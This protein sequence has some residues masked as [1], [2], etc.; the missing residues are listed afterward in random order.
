MNG[1]TRRAWRHAYD[2]SHVAKSTLQLFSCARP[3]LQHTWQR[4]LYL[5]LRSLGSVCVCVAHRHH[6]QS[7]SMPMYYLIA[8][9]QLLYKITK[10]QRHQ[11]AHVALHPERSTAK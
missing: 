11:H 6:D 8:T 10:L 1:D 5:L 3:L 7:P 2:V 4:G 9:R